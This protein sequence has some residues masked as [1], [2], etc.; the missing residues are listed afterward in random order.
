LN[1]HC[2]L[3]LSVGDLTRWEGARSGSPGHGGRSAIV[4]AANETLLGGGGVDGAIHRAAGPDLKLECRALTEIRDGVRCD[5]GEARITAGYELPVDHIIHTVGPRYESEAVS[6]PLLMACYEASLQLAGEHGVEVIAFP[7]ISCG[8]FGYPAAE[9][10][11]AAFAGCRQ[12][13]PRLKLV[14]FVLFSPRLLDIWSAAASRW[15]R[16]E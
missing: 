1:P 14:E 15:G 4:N 8:V 16:A 9:A 5:V 12:S 3:R 10:A 2:E 6:R 7:A 13:E 11:D